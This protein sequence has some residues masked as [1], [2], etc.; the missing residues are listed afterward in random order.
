[1]VVR[2]S[3]ARDQRIVEFKDHIRA[4]YAALV[5]PDAVPALADLAGTLTGVLRNYVPTA[6]VQIEWA[7]AADIDLPAP[8]G[9]VRLCED[10]FSAPVDRVGH[11]LQRAFILSLLQVLTTTQVSA[12]EGEPE[13]PRPAAPDLILAIEEPELYQHPNRQRHFSQVLN[14]LAAGRLPG[15]ARR[16]QVLYC[17]HSPLFVDIAMFNAVRRLRKISNPADI[18]SPLVS[19][20]SSAIAQTLATRLERAQRPAPRNPFS[21]DSLLARCAHL[22][23]PLLNEGFFADVAVLVE[24]EE[25][26]AAVSGCAEAMG[27][28]LESLGVA[29]LPVGG[30]TNLDRPYLVFTGLLIPTY[31]VF[32]SDVDL[33]AAGH[34]DTILAL[35]RLV[36]VPEADIARFPPTRVEDWYAT[37]SPNLTAYIRAAVGNAYE[38]AVAAY[39]EE[40]GY[41]DAHACHKSS[42]FVASLLR[43]L[44]VRPDALPELRNLVA[45][46]HRLSPHAAR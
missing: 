5:N 35:Q 4:Q 43:P 19:Q 30:K 24:G 2:S 27:I 8:K 36:D 17:T 33:G 25:D 9:S 22:M 32:D 21:G 11:G 12:A 18:E 29:V 37:F 23:G 3:I 28:S 1:M 38:A 46:V 34:G 20:C 42:R 16:T 41:P 26:R 44:L 14:S 40:H 10:G 39:R 7:S 6:S 15:V 45:R 13:N 31:V